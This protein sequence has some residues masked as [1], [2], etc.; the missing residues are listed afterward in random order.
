MKWI[1]L[2]FPLVVALGAWAFYAGW[3][4]PRYDPWAALDLREEPNLLSRWK[5]YRMRDDRQACLMA[6]EEAEAGFVVARDQPGGDC[7][8]ENLVRVGS[9]GVGFN[10]GFT[11]TCG[12]AAAWEMFR[13][14]TLQPAAMRHFGVQVERVDHLGTFA[15][16]NVYGREEGRRSQHATANAI[17][18]AGFRLADGTRISVLSD[19]DNQAQP[20][21][22][23]FLRD[24]HEGACGV[25]NGVLGPEYNAA[26]RDHFHLD[27]GGFLVCR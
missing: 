5:L 7:P 26:H 10:Q 12:L 18:I 11:A 2:I 23:A 22:M 9:G 25:F 19:W 27:M 16:R 15:C 8:L 17:D 3:V 13:R 14:H 21:K 20:K 6:L 1:G 4:P 24:I